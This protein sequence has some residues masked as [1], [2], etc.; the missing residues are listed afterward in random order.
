MRLLQTP[1]HLLAYLLIISLTW[2]TTIASTLPRRSGP[3]SRV[4]GPEYVG[5][6]Q[7]S[8]VVTYHQDTL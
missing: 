5:Q 2:H 6:I 1:P 3:R 7:G 4:V 8:Q